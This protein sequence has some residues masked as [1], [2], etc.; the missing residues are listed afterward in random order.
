MGQSLAGRT[1][2]VAVRIG[3]AH[4]FDVAKPFEVLPAQ[5]HPTCKACTIYRSLCVRMSIPGCGWSLYLAKGT[6][7][8][9]ANSSPIQGLCRT[10][11]QLQMLTCSFPGE[12]VN[13]SRS[14]DCLLSLYLHWRYRPSNA[15]PRPASLHRPSRAHAAR[16]QD[17]H[18][19]AIP[20]P[21]RLSPR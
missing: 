10:P 8:S 19:K 14:F 12:A 20:R 21:P 15:R 2:L 16:R 13:K 18:Q 7:F 4:C 5:P 9:S 6:S 1:V 3:T 17:L 11:P